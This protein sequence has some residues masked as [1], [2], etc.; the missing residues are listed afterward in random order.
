[1]DR[2]NYLID[3]VQI[4]HYYNENGDRAFKF[5]NNTD[6]VVTFHIDYYFSSVMFPYYREFVPVGK[7][8]WRSVGTKLLEN[9]SFITINNEESDPSNFNRMITLLP[10]R[11]LKKLNEKVICVGLNKTGTSSLTQDMG[12]LGYN[13]W[14]VHWDLKLSHSMYHFSNNSIGTSIDLIEKT[15]VDFF[16]DIPF[17][18][19]GISERIINLYPQCK[20]ILT[21]RESP[22]KWVNSVKNFWGAFFDENGLVSRTTD[23]KETWINGHTTSL[24][25]YLYNMLLTWNLDSYEGNIDEKLAQVYENHNKNIV[26][27]LESNN[28]DWIDIDVSKKG[29]FKRLTD[30]LGVDTIK[31]DFSWINKTDTTT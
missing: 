17:S 2:H 22:E 4:E 25:N 15:N 26:N 30:W 9:C 27:H 21:K 19:P 20:Y 24:S 3:D 23:R 8:Q 18:C 16:Q 10:N 5:V 1:M 7:N 31:N 14:G 11:K 29:D 12:E 13:T 28:C 6:K